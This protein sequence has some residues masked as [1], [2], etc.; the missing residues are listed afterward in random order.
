MTDPKTAAA[1]TLTLFGPMQVLVKGL[2]IPHLR[3]R[4]ALWLL[5][6][7]ALR[8]GRPVERGW[9]A[10]TLW[11]DA[12][13]EQALAGLRTVL[14]ELRA[15]LGGAGE[16]IQSLGRHTLRLDL[17]GADVD[18]S[19][20]DAAIAEK[21]PAALARAA[22]LYTGPLLEGCAEEWV[23]QERIAREQ[24]CLRALLALA[25]TAL[26]TGNHAAAGDF[27]QRAVALDPWRDAAR[28]G[29]MESLS[30]GGS[31]NAALQVYREFVALLRDDPKAA[32]D[33]QTRALYARLRAE[34]RRQ[35]AG[36]SRLATQEIVPVPAVTGYLPHSL[37]DLVGREDESLEV[38]ARLR[39][40]RLVTLTGP[41]GIGK[42]RMALAVA[43]EAAPDYADGVWLVA[44]DSLADGARVP[45][46]IANVLEL[47]EEACRS[48]LQI[49][50][51]YLRSKRLLLVLDNCEHLLAACAQA[52]GHL[53]RECA[54]VRILATSR[55][56]LGVTGEAAW[57][58]PGLTVPDPAHL[59]PA[60]AS[61][62]RVLA[63]YEG[64][65]LFVERAQSVQKTFALT[66]DNGRLV[67]EIC[68]RLGGLPLAIELAA[69]RVKV[70]TVGQIAARL[71]DYL[72]LL[73]GGSRVAPTRQ[74]T[75]RAT[76]DW[77][78]NLLDEAERCLLAR[79]SVFAGGWTLEA[80]EAVC[81]GDGIQTGQILDLLASLTDKSLV[82]FEERPE[83]GDGRY[84]LLEMVRQYAAAQL[85]PGGET[86]HFKKQHQNHYLT[87]AEVIE[88]KLRRAEQQKW[89]DCLE[90]DHANF[91]AALAWQGQDAD[92]P[93]IGL[94]L[95]GALWW[96]WY[97]RG[98]L[99]EGLQNLSRVLE[100]EG[101]QNPTPARS[102]ALTAA[103]TLSCIQGDY[104]AGRTYFEESLSIERHLGSRQE[105]AVTLGNLGNIALDQGRYESARALFEESLV[106]FR[107]LG[108][109][110]LTA[111]SLGNLGQVAYALG[112]HGAAQTLHTDALH[113]FQE[114]E[115]RQAIALTLDSLGQV[116]CARTDL[117]SAQALH[118]ES[119]SLFRDLQD[120]GGIPKS[121]IGLGN[122]ARQRGDY[123]QAQALF[124]ESLKI[125]RNTRDKK[126]LA[127]G[128]MELGT[129]LL[130]QSV[131]IKAVR[132]WAAAA[133]LRESVG[134][135]LSPYDCK[136]QDQ[137]VAMAR[138]ALGDEAF[139]SAW[140]SGCALTQ[141]QAVATALE[142]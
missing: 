7:L 19:A 120:L 63:G 12:D 33:E 107:D 41:G 26:A 13:P 75:L 105:I 65:R 37:T 95:A 115:D 24:D 56:A 100:P 51:D 122:V 47:K 85:A 123:A 136:R 3:S 78:Y 135:A 50:T 10:D 94:R 87:W 109:R 101:A 8:G 106:V 92:G 38:T 114:L 86:E 35:S 54:E 130:T 53:L 124:L 23:G 20:F 103:G 134:L 93:M 39:R 69:A 137:H 112:E 45:A 118:E 62:M 70:L 44:L 129:L 83:A 43:A 77:S 79:L 117:V 91:Q 14:S 9:L 42:T 71:D 5:A 2:P 97:V 90:V 111:A 25:D 72:G 49:L 102:K 32:P 40:S 57:A 96:F 46:Q 6:L 121:L 127:D 36:P 110:H 59:P 108:R 104:L 31:V 58:V 99:S 66:A 64:V 11:P 67:A 30:R 60:R 141:E 74:Q 125:S 22:A 140:E 48:L 28:Q 84:R 142:E 55:E 18:V 68:A 1:L 119:L 61:L 138:A 88:P 82:V 89:L 128:L 4:K 133:T 16:R 21:T 81:A 73:T 27:Y 15:A 52:A 139:T 113:I 126:A 17:T 131:A 29:L 132:L 98:Y 76:L 80:A 34:A 116:A